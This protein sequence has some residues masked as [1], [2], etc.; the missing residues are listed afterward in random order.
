MR[1]MTCG[2]RAAR[3]R[4]ERGVIEPVGEGE[5]LTGWSELIAI[6]RGVAPAQNGA[7]QVR[8]EARTA[9]E[10]TRNSPRRGPVSFSWSTIGYTL[11]VDAHAGTS[12]T[13][14]HPRG[15][16]RARAARRHRGRTRRAARP[17]AHRA[18][19][20]QGGT[21]DRGTDPA[22]PPAAGPRRLQR[23]AG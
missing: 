17:A 5:P 8:A 7:E 6:G 23:A 14:P 9:P 15:E 10:C 21:C 3:G 1:R 19:T 12:D 22:L 2:S 18:R 4:G 13:A 16:R 11:E 20:R